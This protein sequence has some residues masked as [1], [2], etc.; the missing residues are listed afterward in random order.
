MQH[1]MT[2][3]KVLKYKNR[4]LEKLSKVSGEIRHWNSIVVGAER[5]KD[6]EALMEERKKL[7]ENLIATKMAI[8]KANGPIQ[9]DIFR[10]AEIKGEI[11]LLNELSTRHGKHLPE[12]GYRMSGDAAQMIEYVACIRKADVDAAVERLGKQVDELQ[13]R[14]DKHN[15]MTEV[16]LEVIF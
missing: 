8:F 13:D 6:A 5:E 11:S 2:L 4:L 10:L 12:F 3:A 14:L 15:H 16:T 1:T 7:V 9:E